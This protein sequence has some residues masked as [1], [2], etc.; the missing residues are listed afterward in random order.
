[1]DPE[2]PSH[3]QGWSADG[4]VLAM[5]T[6]LMA[7]T[8]AF[9]P[10]P[11]WLVVPAP[12]AALAYRHGYRLSVG[13]A[14][15][16]VI[17][18]GYV[19]QQVFAGLA[20]ALPAESLRFSLLGV[21]VVPV[22]LGLIGLVI[23]GA[24]REGAGAGQTLALAV[25]AALLPGAALWTG[26]RLAHGIDLVAVLVDNWLQLART[27][28]DQAAAGGVAP[29]AVESLRLMI[30]ETERSFAAIR[31]FLPGF[32]V[33]AACGAA[34]L[35]LALTRVLLVRLGEAPPWFP[36]FARWR[37]PWPLA[38]G[39]IAGHGLLVAGTVADQEGL[40]VVGENLRI[41]FHL[42]FTVQGL[43][44][45]WYWL[46]VRRLAPLWRFLLLA[47]LLLWVPAVVAGAG[48]LDTWFNFRRLPLPDNGNDDGGDGAGDGRR[49]DG[50]LAGTI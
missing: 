5:A 21:L 26:V 7:L 43:A 30:T 33:A 48:V 31:P 14:V 6:V 16:A 35:N 19:E 15:L 18:V 12:L 50:G 28:A 39:F 13:T 17:L 3:D 45:G 34:A 4:I 24:W 23:G 41:M 10:L 42:L 36:P 8:G 22:T 25:L 46:E 11:L 44:V 1:M 29:E 49:E 37:F 38:L 2:R 32:A 40:V 20:Q 9:F 27:M 47:L